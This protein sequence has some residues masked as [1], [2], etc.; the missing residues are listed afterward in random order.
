MLKVTS[1]ENRPELQHSQYPM[2]FFF[3]FSKFPAMRSPH[4]A[5]RCVRAPDNSHNRGL[6]VS[7]GIV[8]FAADRHS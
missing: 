5:S 4:P 7:H 2:E 6:A 8:V 1:L 3:F